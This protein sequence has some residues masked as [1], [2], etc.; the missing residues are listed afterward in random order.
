M[1]AWN[2][3]KRG[4][5]YDVITDTASERAFWI[6]EEHKEVQFNAAILIEEPHILHCFNNSEHLLGY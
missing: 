5:K 6:L 4:E 2:F 1:A 3:S